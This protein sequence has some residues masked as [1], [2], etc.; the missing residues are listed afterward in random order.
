MSDDQTSETAEPLAPADLAGWFL[1]G[2]RLCANAA[3]ALAHTPDPGVGDHTRGMFGHA[4]VRIADDA[5]A[6]VPDALLALAGP[7]AMQW[8]ECKGQEPT[9]DEQAHVVLAVLNRLAPEAPP[10]AEPPEAPE[11]HMPGYL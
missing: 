8:R 10:Q 2:A 9:S 1:Y 3:W 5:L 7:E 6:T 4:A 11:P